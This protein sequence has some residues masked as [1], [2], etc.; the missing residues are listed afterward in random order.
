M[1]I[2]FYPLLSIDFLEDEN[3]KKKMSLVFMFIH[4]SLPSS[5]KN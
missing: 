2:M 5:M 3:F 1:F 4:V